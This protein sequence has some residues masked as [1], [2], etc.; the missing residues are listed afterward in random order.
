M[1]VN[2][3]DDYPMS[4]KP[5][6]KNISGSIT[7]N[8]AK[9][10]ED[11]IE[12]GVLNPGTKLPPQR[13]LADYL[14]INLSTV[15]R[16]FKICEEK[17]LICAT[18]GKGTFV[19]TDVHI[20]KTM[21]DTLN[22]GNLIEMGAAHPTYEQNSYI[23]EAIKE[24]LNRP[25]INKLFEYNDVKGSIYQKR[26]ISNFINGECEIPCKEE[27]IVFSAGGQ[28]AL[29]CILLGLFNSGDKIGVDSLIYPGLKSMVNI[30]KI[31]LIPIAND[32]N[33]MNPD[34]LDVVCKNEKIDGI[35]LINDIHNPTTL[36]LDE[37]RR[38]EIG[39]IAK[40]HNLIIIEDGIH[41]LFLDKLPK[42]LYEM[43][44]ENTVHISSMSKIICPGL[45]VGVIITPKKYKKQLET[46]L[47]N[48]NVMVPNLQ[49]EAIC[50]II[51]NKIYKKIISERKTIIKNRMKIA[52]EMLINNNCNYNKGANLIFLKLPHNF[53][54]GK[55]EDLCKEKGVQV[56]SSK[57]FV[58][59][60]VD[61]IPSI[62]LCITAHKNEDELIEGLNIIINELKKSQHK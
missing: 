61:T 55:F 51:N 23:V 56:Y 62:R 39:Q 60:N 49:V 28:N 44:S 54:S 1:P 8:L 31:K 19:S 16:A 50:H 11:D 5:S 34:T 58:V 29:S 13:E 26:I 53:D 4:W 46:S 35:Y 47:Y 25:D 12:R 32:E 59:G 40:K 18:I 57:R 36:V 42:T 17:G 3:F 43:E 24:I 6:L 30:C 41:R 22:K 14:D 2:S 15:T 27:N 9:L 7:K 33:G 37:K 20:K 10:L 38:R 45:R 48:V 21:I 52:E